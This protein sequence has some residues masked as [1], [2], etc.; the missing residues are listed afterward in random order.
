MGFTALETLKRWWQRLRQ[1]MQ[2]FLHQRVFAIK[3]SSNTPQDCSEEKSNPTQLFPRQPA[4][5]NAP[6]KR[7]TQNPA[8][9][10]RN[11]SFVADLQQRMLNKYGPE[12]IRETYGRDTIPDCAIAFEARTTEFYRW[13]KGMLS[14]SSA[15]HRK[16]VAVLTSDKLPRK[17]RPGGTRA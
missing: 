17:P 13:R 8:I 10:A 15:A 14:D 9:E 6:Y 5:R 11:L 7:Y 3:G 16:I 1:W 4:P 12:K 2:L